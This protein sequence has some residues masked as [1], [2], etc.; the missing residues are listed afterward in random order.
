MGQRM[1]RLGSRRQSL[2]AQT[3]TAAAAFAPTD[4]AGL[5]GWYDFSAISSLWQDTG[6]TSA[7][8]ADGQTIK[9]VTDLSGSGAHLSEATNGPTYKASIQNSL[10]VARFD[11]TNDVLRESTGWGLGNANVNAVTYTVFVVMV[12]TDAASDSFFN[13]SSTALANTLYHRTTAGAY[14]IFK[15]GDAANQVS[16]TGGSVDTSWHVQEILSPGTTVTWLV[17]G[18]SIITAA[19]FSAVADSF[20]PNQGGVGALIYNGTT[21]NS[22]HFGDIA[23]LVLYNSSLSAG[24]RSSVRSYLGT[25]WGITVA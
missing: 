15:Y 6:R 22:F 1:V 19:A 8:S 23:E 12:R 18:S 7:V 14:F 17:D 13:P 10:S 4:V 3:F 2:V 25:K 5:A 16:A 20:T 21:P 9:G 11:G 24:N